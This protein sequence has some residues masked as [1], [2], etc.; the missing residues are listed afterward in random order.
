[1]QVLSA[2]STVKLVCTRVKESQTHRRLHRTFF[3]FIRTIQRRKLFFKLKKSSFSSRKLYTNNERNEGTFFQP[4]ERKFSSSGQEKSSFISLQ[5]L[6]Y[7]VNAKAGKLFCS[8]HILSHTN[9]AFNVFDDYSEVHLKKNFL[10]TKK[11]SLFTAK[12]ILSEQ[13]IPTDDKVKT[14]KLHTLTKQLKYNKAA[15]IVL[16]LPLLLLL[17]LLLLPLSTC[18][19]PGLSGALSALQSSSIATKI[20]LH[21]SHTHTKKKKKKTHPHP[22][23]HPPSC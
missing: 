23:P 4:A 22:T 15:I 21:K 16:L 5:V 19:A 9:Y 6:R 13:S 11:P 18:T 14:L 20:H 10:K 2:R 17:L 12:L 3:C 8:V 7:H 1:M